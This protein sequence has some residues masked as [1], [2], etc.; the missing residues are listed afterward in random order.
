M[1]YCGPLGIPRSVFLGRTVEDGEPY[2]TKTDVDWALSWQ[3]VKNETCQGCGQSLVESTD[4]EFQGAF[5]VETV[6]C[7]GCAEKEK[8]HEAQ[9]KSKG[10]KRDPGSRTLVTLPDWKREAVHKHV[11]DKRMREVM[12]DG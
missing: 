7:H 4:I 8:A 12:A 11:A 5:D 6:V 9:S 2:W 1:D 10:T 3:Q